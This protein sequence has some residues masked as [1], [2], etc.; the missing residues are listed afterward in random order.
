MKTLVQSEYRFKK[1]ADN[2]NEV[3]LVV[4]IDYEDSCYDITQHGQEGIMP[5]ENNGG[6]EQNLAYFELAI[7]ALNFIKTE[8]YD[9]ATSDKSNG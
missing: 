4:D 3:E 9:Q 8:V 7:E 1:E 2:G 6:V 5:K